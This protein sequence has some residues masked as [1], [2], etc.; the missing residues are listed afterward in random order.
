MTV[1]LHAGDAALTVDPERG[2]R[3]TSWR[4]G[5]LELLGSPTEPLAPQFDGG[6]FVMA[7]IAGR[8]GR[9][10]PPAIHGTVAGAPWH[11]DHAGRHGADLTARGEGFAIHQRLRLYADRLDTALTLRPDTAL[12][13][14]IGWHPYFPRRLARGGDAEWRLDGGTQYARGSD[15]L[16]TGEL[17]DRRPGPWDDAF[18][19]FA[20]PPAIAWPGALTLTAESSHAHFVLFDERPEVVCLEPQTGPPDAARLG[21]AARL[22]PGEELTLA[23]TWRW[24]PTT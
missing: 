18:R 9:R 2:A 11:H 3:W 20:A 15:H 7:P 6:C 13:P 8:D 22:Q 4:V 17:H 16:P 5:D 19:D 1:T 24:A 14:W 21:E 23:V 10:S 12:Q